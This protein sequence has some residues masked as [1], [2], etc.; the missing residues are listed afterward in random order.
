[1]NLIWEPYCFMTSDKKPF[2]TRLGNDFSG[3]ASKAWS[4]K[5]QIGKLDIKKNL[6]VYSLKDTVKRMSQATSWEK[7]FVYHVFGK[8]SVFKRYEEPLKVTKKQPQ[9]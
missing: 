3:V 2:D 9:N 7:I 5:E 6:T 1:M 8:G 4:I